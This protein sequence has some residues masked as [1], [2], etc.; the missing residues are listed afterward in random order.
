M[1]IKLNFDGYWRDS[2]KNGVPNESGIYLVY[3][4]KHNVSE[5]SVALKE[6]LYIGESKEM[7][8]RLAKHERYYDWEA[9]LNRGEEL[10]YAY[11]KV[12]KTERVLGEAALINYHKPPEN[13]EYVDEFPYGS[14]T[15][16]SS[17][18]CRFI[19]SPITVY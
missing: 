18:T 4:C 7:R 19:E 12:G 2:V 8:D 16:L 10:C 11:T 5:G 13:T 3:R 9:H 15:V 6:L 17:G 14:T 1:E